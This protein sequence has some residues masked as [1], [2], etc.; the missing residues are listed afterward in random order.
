[1]RREQQHGCEPFGCIGCGR[2][3][4]RPVSCAMPGPAEARRRAGI[5]RPKRPEPAPPARPD[6]QAA[7]RL[8]RGHQLG[9]MVAVEIRDGHGSQRL[10]T[11]ND[12]GR[13][14]GREP[15]TDDRRLVRGE[16]DAILEAIAVEVAGQGP[17]MGLG[18]RDDKKRTQARK[19]QGTTQTRRHAGH[20]NMK[21]TTGHDAARFTSW[22]SFA[23][24]A[25]LS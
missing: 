21:Y 4:R 8:V 6:V 1:M 15:D 11:A 7:G 13:L 17:L 23:A 12:V 10:G 19:P 22:M 5:G 2:C 3:L 25:G 9:A 20:C 16:G 24:A 18:A 14:R